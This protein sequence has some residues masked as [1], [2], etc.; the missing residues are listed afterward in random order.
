MAGDA[1]PDPGSLVAMEMT[2]SQNSR[3]QEPAMNHQENL[4][5]ISK[6]VARSEYRSRR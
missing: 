2:G 4:D 3:Q 1:V 6:K 5:T